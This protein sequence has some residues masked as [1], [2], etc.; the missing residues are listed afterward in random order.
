MVYLYVE[1]YTLFKVWIR[2]CTDVL[3]VSIN[4]AVARNLCA[5]WGGGGCV[6]VGGWWGDKPEARQ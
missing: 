4:M 5:G 1:L 3:T 2:C 6:V